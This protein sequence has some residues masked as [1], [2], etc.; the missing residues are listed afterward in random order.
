MTFVI[1][2]T[3]LFYA[4]LRFDNSYI[5]VTFDLIWLICYFYLFLPFFWKAVFRDKLSGCSS[6]HPVSSIEALI[7]GITKHWSK[8]VSSLHPFESTTA[9]LLDSVWLLLAKF[10]YWY[11]LISYNLHSWNQHYLHLSLNWSL[12]RIGTTFILLLF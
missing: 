11:Q 2:L 12:I 6:D 5:K 9:I 4:R 3:Y 7:E 8:P 1:L 10:V